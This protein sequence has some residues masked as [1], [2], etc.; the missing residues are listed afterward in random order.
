MRYCGYCGKKMKK[1]L[2]PVTEFNIHTGK[3]VVYVIYKCPNKRWW[4][5]R[6][7]DQSDRKD[8]DRPIGPAQEGI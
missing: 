2:L 5:L 6:H 7:E 8:D 1:S 4:N 3:R